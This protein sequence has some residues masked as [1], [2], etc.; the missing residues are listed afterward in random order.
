M[1]KSAITSIV[2]PAWILIT[3]GFTVS[4][5]ITFMG[6]PSV[7]KIAR[8]KNLYDIPGKR[9]SH[10][11]PTPRLG[12]SMI[13][14]GVIL[15]SV[16]FTGMGKA[17]EL[18]YIIAGLIV[19][20]FIGLKDDIITLVPAKKAAGQLIAS[21]IIVIFGGIRISFNYSLF[22][23]PELSYLLS[24]LI[25]LILVMTLINSLNFIDGIDGLAAG[26]GIIASTSFGTWFVLN[27]QISL[28]VICFSL[29]GSLIAFFW[30]NVFSK[31]F[32]IFLG[33]TGS[34]VIGFLLAVF[35]MRFLE[36]NFHGPVYK[37]TDVAP[38]LAL[39][40]LIV[41][42]FDVF[43]IVLIRIMNRKSPF[44]G[45]HNHIHHKVLKLSGSH[46][47]ATSVILLVNILLIIITLLLRS[48]GNTILI[49][50]L[51]LICVGLSATVFFLIKNGT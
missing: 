49:S 17:F 22:G 28:A 15:S 44:F 19:L 27:D 6:I 2:L 24:L 37:T 33:D 48:L 51:L 20:F 1:F 40:I 32:K 38:S 36:L 45:D 18:K 12:G 23:I 8:A 31:K 47:K 34:M 13:F 43:R 21:L 41:P 30:Y 50:F 25:S 9:T 5:F 14:A 35:L 10:I 7:I 29:S 4:F 42:V 11:E 3:A 39:A 16:L 26:V 46:I